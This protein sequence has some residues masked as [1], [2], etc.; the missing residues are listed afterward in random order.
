MQLRASP[1]VR[2]GVTAASD[3]FL[4]ARTR[5]GV[6]LTMAPSIQGDLSLLPWLK[7]RGEYDFAYAYTQVNAGSSYDHLGA[8]TIRTRPF[9]RWWLEVAGKAA[10]QRFTVVGTAED[11]PGRLLTSYDAVSASP[12]LRY[13]GDHAELSLG[14]AFMSARSEDQQFGEVFEHANRAIAKASWSPQEGIAAGFQYRFTLNHATV[15][16]L[17]Y[18]SHEGVV[19]GALR[20][21]QRAWLRLEAGLQYSAFAV[22]RIDPAS[23]DPFPRRD[24]LARGSLGLTVALRDG[25]A[26][27]FAYGYARNFST[28]ASAVA[29]RHM[30]YAGVR[31]EVDPWRY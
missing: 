15:G 25:V 11:I 17:V 3:L 28:D 4:G 10:V 29:D 23:G 26:F 30:G 18:Q 13:L 22:E 12:Q 14:Y 2:S 27:E 24:G 8:L 21:F 16:D 20:L 19:T 31:A 6:E 1:L 7:L 5:P 9:G